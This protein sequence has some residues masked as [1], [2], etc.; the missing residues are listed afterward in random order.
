MVSYPTHTR[1]LKQRSFSKERPLALQ[2]VL[3]LAVCLLEIAFLES[4]AS[5]MDALAMRASVK[6]LCYKK[7][8]QG[9]GHTLQFL[10][11]LWQC[12][13]KQPYCAASPVKV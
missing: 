9:S 13:C 6:H 12:W 10:A 8:S 7:K 5:E 1:S 4:A 11:C 2:L 3:W